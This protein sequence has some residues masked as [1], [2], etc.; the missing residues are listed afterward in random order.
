MVDEAQITMTSIKGFALV[1]AVAFIYLAVRLLPRLLLGFKAYL[2]PEKV[3]QLMQSDDQILLLDVRSSSE[4]SGE[5]GHIPKALNIPLNVLLQW[6]EN[7]LE[8][9]QSKHV[10]IICR[11]DTRAAF[12]GR[13]L[14]RAGFTHVSVMSGGMSAW[15][16]DG[17]TVVWN[18]SSQGSRYVGY[19]DDVCRKKNT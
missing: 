9:E 6:S 16:D 2:S 7:A 4:F 13:M 10:I 1:I 5:L 12:A 11:T 15:V 3:L 18:R 19:V 8:T 17:R 14:K